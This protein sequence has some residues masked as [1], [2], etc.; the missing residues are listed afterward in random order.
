VVE[1]SIVGRSVMYEVRR[2]ISSGC[3][4][5]RP[6]S[7]STCRETM[8]PLPFVWPYAVIYWAIYAWA[9]LP[10]WKIVKDARRNAKRPDSRDAGSIGFLLLGMWIALLVAY[11]VAFIRAWS[12]PASARIPLFVVGAAMIL[13]GSLL[14][15]YCWRTLGK[16]FTGDVQAQSD[17]PVIR[18]GPYRIVRHPSYTGAMMMFIGIGLS[19]GSWASFLLLTAATIVAYGYRVIVE[20][21]V[22][23][24]TLGAPYGVYMKERKR[25]IPYIV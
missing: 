20:E 13:L 7:T 4:Y 23:L 5:V 3:A 24:E 17:Q 1:A 15:R 21:R 12:F 11:P 25:F 8:R 6:S 9:F 19:L 16:Y 22:L 10:E 14:R 2:G 18:T